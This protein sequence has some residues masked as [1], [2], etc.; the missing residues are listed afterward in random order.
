MRPRPIALFVASLL[1]VVPTATTAAPVPLEESPDPSEGPTILVSGRGAAH[2]MGLAMDGVEGQA[3]AG[4][5]HDRILDLFYPGT[6][7]GSFGG[8]V[9]VGLADDP[10]SLAFTLPSGGRIA[11]ASGDL[12]ADAPAGAR[13]IVTFEDGRY[14]VEAPGVVQAAQDDPPVPLPS[15]DPDDPDDPTV[16]EP[17]PTPEP[18]PTPEATPEPSAPGSAEPIWITPSGDPA[19]THVEATGRRYRER[20]EVRFSPNSESLW[21]INHVDLETY[22]MGIAE[23]KGQ[24]WPIE[25]L[26]VLAV[27]ARSLAASTMTWYE[28]RHPNGFDICP[29]AACQ[30]YLGYD[31]EEP[32]M[33]EATRQTAGE[34]R[35]YNGRSILAMYHGN[36]GGK[37]DEYE[38]LYGNGRTDPHPYLRAVEYPY[39]DP[40]DWRLAFG[41]DDVTERLRESEVD[42]PGTFRRAQ[43]L[44]TGAS[45]RVVRMRIEGSEGT[46]ETAGRTFQAALDL[47]SAWFEVRAAEE[48]PVP[49]EEPK[50]ALPVR[51]GSN[52]V[53]ADAPAPPAPSAAE[54]LD[55]GRPWA[56]LALA[57]LCASTVALVA[58]DR[59][60]GREA[61]RTRR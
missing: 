20:M 47:P 14:L 39:A 15:D 1:V 51:G 18:D 28:R 23:E 56:L 36:G 26:K 4:W 37:T 27:A 54:P 8:T 9:R 35:T 30:V 44:Q 29:T 21:A 58:G 50:G 12:L 42:V 5:S 2:G 25:G 24:G 11:D 53:T 48:E 55:A 40:S 13:V 52:L 57:L 31:G 46:V 19:L 49:P 34:I 33:R 45:P 7:T 10:R 16:P 59:R 17:T 61:T 41:A 43:I 6:A 38:L 60:F 3:R 32:A 22:V